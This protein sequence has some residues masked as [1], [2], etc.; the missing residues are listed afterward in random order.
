MM[1]QLYG[2]DGE[3]AHLLNDFVPGDTYNAKVYPPD[4]AVLIP[5]HSDLIFELHYTPNG[6]EATTDQSMVAFQWAEAPP[7]HQVHTTVFRKPIGGFRI[8]PHHP[9]YRVEDT[10][11]FAHDIEIDGIRPHFHLR[12]KSFRLEMIERD[13]KT[14][15]ITRRTTILSVPIFDQAWQRTYELAK[16]LRLPAGTE[17]LATGHF[18]NSALNPN[19]PDPNA[20]V[21][22]GQQ[23]TDEMFSTRFK[24]RIC[25]E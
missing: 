21:V 25:D 18:D 14:D 6:R 24:F 10:Y 11:H 1:A 5:K 3:R 9:H 7:K 19:N 12:G 13:P 15:D 23:T 16:P 22:W 20:T 2:V 4:Q 17:L 8:P